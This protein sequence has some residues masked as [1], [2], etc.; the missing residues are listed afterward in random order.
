[1]KRWIYSVNEDELI[2]LYERFPQG[3]EIVGRDGKRIEVAIYSPRRPDLPL[4]PLR[5]EEVKTPDWKSFYKPID[6]GKVLVVPP[7]EKT[8][9]E[10]DKTVLVI[11]PGKAFGTGLHE[12]TRLCLR[13]LSEED[14]EKKRVLDVGSGS[15]I[16]SIYAAKRGASVTAVDVDPLAVEETLKNARLNGVESS[17]EVKLGGPEVAG[18][19]FDLVVANLELPVFK[20]VLDQVVERSKRDLLFS[21]IYKKRELKEFLKMLKELGVE[22][23]KVEEENG[24]F[25]I[26]G[27]KDAVDGEG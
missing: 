8:I 20:K 27:V 22:V 5:S 26:R 10:G 14:L 21:G 18:E 19:G 2:E 6:L 12:S 1:M 17:V 16:L 4:Q 13:L 25:A 11:E 7:W 23:L 24:W 9:P 3:F 15:G